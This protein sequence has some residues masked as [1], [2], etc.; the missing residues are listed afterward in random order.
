M[1][2]RNRLILGLEHFTSSKRSVYSNY[3]SLGRA[4]LKEKNQPLIASDDINKSALVGEFKSF[5]NDKTWLTGMMEWNTTRDQLNSGFINVAHE[6]DTGLSLNI[7]SSYRRNT[8]SSYLVPWAD[9]FEPVKN[10]EFSSQWPIFENLTV[11]TKIKKDME[12]SSSSDILYGFQYSNCC[13][14]AGLMKRK[15][16]EQDYFSWKA[17]YLDPFSALSDGYSPI[18]ERDNIYIFLEFKQ[19]GRLGKEISEVI[20]ST[21]LE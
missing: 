20:S 15:W 9:R 6:S 8:S 18:K 19:I 17:D 21:L 13:L 4:F 16:K 2:D 10:I 7:K 12:R 5:L 11:F 1:S 3:F 14:K